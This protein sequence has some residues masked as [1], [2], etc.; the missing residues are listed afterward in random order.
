M[1]EIQAEIFC[2]VKQRSAIFFLLLLLQS[3]INWK[4]SVFLWFIQQYKHIP[5][6]WITPYQFG[7]I[8]ILGFAMLLINVFGNGDRERE[9]ERKTQWKWNIWQTWLE[10]LL[11]RGRTIVYSILNKSDKNF[12]AMHRSLNVGRDA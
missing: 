9:G 8:T 2:N 4:S 6:W 12:C 10:A 7:C 11:N 1:F 5:N 3:W